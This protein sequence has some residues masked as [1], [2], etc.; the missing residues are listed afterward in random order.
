MIFQGLPPS[1]TAPELRQLFSKFGDIVA[2][3][4]LEHNGHGGNGQG[5]GVGFVR[6]DKV[7]VYILFLVLLDFI[8][9]E[10]I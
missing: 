3:R 8:N 6:F 5:R 2:V 7:G 4:V 1:M 10:I 9:S